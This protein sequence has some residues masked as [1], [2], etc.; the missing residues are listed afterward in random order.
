DRGFFA[1]GS[2]L[3][4]QPVSAKNE[5]EPLDSASS[6]KLSLNGLGSSSVQSRQRMEQ[7]FFRQR[8][9]RSLRGL[10]FRWH[11]DG[12]RRRAAATWSRARARVAA[13]VPVSH[14]AAPMIAQMA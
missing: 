13:P 1:A 10:L 6:S 11:F 5:A 7:G 8:F 4:W 12:G 9:R 14:E 2:A 3:I